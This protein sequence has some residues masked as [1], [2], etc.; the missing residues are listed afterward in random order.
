[1][2]LITGGAMLLPACVKN[3]K[4]VSIQLKNLKI[5]A[6]QEALLAEITETII[7]ATDTPGAKDIGLHKFVLRMVDDCSEPEEQQTFLTGL[8]QFEEM[9]KQKSGD[10]FLE[11]DKG[12]REQ[13]VKALDAIKSG[14]DNEEKEKPINA[15][16]SKVKDL[17]VRGYMTSEFVMTKQLYYKMIPG[18]FKG[19]VEIKDAKD[20]KTIL[21]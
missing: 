1:M 20:F 16:Y 15:F 17:T 8:A 10:N 18:K 9:A 21:G 13:F 5:S 19:C 14:D 3:H 12:Q 7:P 11:M 2:V 4:P 6:E